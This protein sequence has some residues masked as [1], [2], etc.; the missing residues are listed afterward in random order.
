MIGLW[1]D[2]RRSGSQRA[3]TALS[4][5]AAP[6]LRA[7]MTMAMSPAVM[8]I[9]VPL[10]VTPVETGEFLLATSPPIALGNVQA[11]TKHDDG[12]K[13]RYYIPVHDF[14][15]YVIT[16]I[17]QFFILSHGAIPRDSRI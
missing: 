15:P 4:K 2:D 17:Y 5:F 11:A 12:E 14:T 16:F 6:A 10:P 3:R 13:C 8:T 7:M 1:R 9:I